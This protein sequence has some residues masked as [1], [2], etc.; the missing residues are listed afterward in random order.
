MVASYVS[1]TMSSF[2]ISL[3]LAVFR[4][5]DYVLVHETSPVMIGIPGV[6]VSR[7]QK[8]PL[9]FWVLDLW[10]E[11]LIEAG[12]IHNPWILGAFNKLTKWIYR[13]SD[14]ILI[15]SRGFEQSIT[16]KGEDASKI[17]YFPNWSDQREA[18][19]NSHERIAMPEGFVVMFAGNIGVAQDFDHIMEATLMLKEKKNIHFVIAGDGRKRTYLQDFIRDHHLENTVHWL[20]WF[21]QEK[22]RYLYSVADVMLISLKKGLAT[23]LTLPAKIQS[24]MAAGKPI[25]AMLDGEGCRI[26]QEARCGISVN[27]SDASALATAIVELSGTSDEKLKEMGE[28]GKKYQEIHF[29]LDKAI[30]HLISIL[31]NIKKC[32][33][34]RN[35]T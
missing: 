10:P 5:F 26:I 9:L 23:S 8:K 17:V 15:S 6:V 33:V 12:N 28:N 3:Y 1:Y 21:P 4:R 32:E 14:R 20:G 7:I 11:S 19:S 18:T 16:A 29:Q 22:I 27:A 25:V 24:Y 31:N 30:E 35:E 13:H 34:Y 2:F